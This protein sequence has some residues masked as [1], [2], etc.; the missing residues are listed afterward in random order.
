MCESFV[1]VLFCDGLLSVLYSAS[2]ISLGFVAS[3]FVNVHL[4]M[5]LFVSAL[6]SLSLS[7]V[8]YSVIVALF[9]HYHFFTDTCLTA[10]PGVARSI[11]ARSHP[12]VEIDHEKISTVILLPSAESIKKA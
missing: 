4:C 9:G 10:D 6:V 5:P 8:G 2:I 3:L 1:F 7:V 11:P 12:F